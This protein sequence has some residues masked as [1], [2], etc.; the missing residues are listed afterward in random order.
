MA[1]KR[2]NKKLKCKENPCSV[3]SLA[4]RDKNL[5]RSASRLVLHLLLLVSSH[6]KGVRCATWSI[7]T[8]AAAPR[9]H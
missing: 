9:L 7:E 4:R 2:G 8:A 6:L 3:W 5:N 1:T